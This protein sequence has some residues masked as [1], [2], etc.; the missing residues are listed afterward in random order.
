MLDDLRYRIRALVRRADVEA[1]LRDELDAHVAHEARRF[2]DQGL[3]SGEAWRRA[4]VS[5]GG[6]EPVKEA[7]RDAR[8]VS[9]VETALQDLRYAARALLSRPGFTIVAVG[10]LALGL[11]LNAAIFTAVRSVLLRPLPY[12]EPERLVRIWPGRT[13]SN[14][15]LLA[16]QS[17]LKSFQD[18]AAFSPGW[19]VYV[20]GP[21]EPSH[22]EAARV[23]TNF[24]TTLGVTPAMGRVFQSN[25]SSAGAWNV[26]ILSDAV[27]RTLYGADRGVVGRTV[28]IDGTPHVIVGVMPRDLAFHSPVQLWLPLQ[29]DP[30]SPFFSGQSA[31]A[32]GRLRDGVRADRAAGELA[33]IA[34]RIREQY[35]FAPDYGRGSRVIDLRESI[36]GSARAP[37]LA[38]FGAAGLIVLIAGANVGTLLLLRGANRQR[39][40]VVRRALGASRGRIVL[41][42][43]AESLLLSFAGATIGLGLGAAAMR[44]VPAILPDAFPRRGE[45]GM[46]AGVAITIFAIASVV[47]LVF[48]LAPAMLAGRA[49]A[50]IALRS[51]RAGD[52]GTR[53]GA[54]IRSVLIVGEVALALMLSVGAGLMLRTVWS[55][56]AVDM[57]FHADHVL[58]LRLEPERSRV[59][60]PQQR[61]AYYGEVLSRIR[62]V[63]GVVSVGG[64]HHLP[65]S[66]FSWSGF[67]DIERR[68]Q[69]SNATRPRVVWRVIVGDYFRT[70]GIALLRGRAFDARDTRESPAV[71]IISASMARHL[72]PGQ[73]PLGERIRVENG[74]RNDWATVIGIVG[75]VHSNALDV[76]AGDE[77]YRPILQQSQIFTHLVIRTTS[78]PRSAVPAVQA[79]IRQV[80]GAAAISEIASL[81]QIVDRSIA[82]RR[83]VMQLLVV[84]AAVG[85]A[86]GMIGIHGIVAFAVTQ[87]T[88]EL[89]IRAALGSQ[90]GAIVAMLVGHG[91]RLACC[92]IVLGIVGSIIA[93]RWLTTLLFGVS[94]SD[95]LTYGAFGVVTLLVMLVASYV[96]ARRALRIDPAMALRME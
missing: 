4:R 3:S 40:M 20:S 10:T 79:A 65:L 89:G 36:A 12:H 86:L 85:I 56:Y 84:F 14:A 38:L 76:P 28:K 31:L 6:I 68:P 35:G 8:G 19:G 42:L 69:P 22:L 52:G 50:Q 49:E 94:S 78:D 41:L 13:I 9:F 18:V 17:Q 29:I 74:T 51:G 32:V 46:D 61:P 26:A 59:R 63:P 73:D 44:L 77:M 43:L 30:T 15:E 83:A 58:T 53:S 95:P 34:P 47:G 57:G 25:E 80:D 91:V 7:C 87:R 92:G 27:W 11:G 1:E 93:N 5:L 70:M 54:R 75:D 55:L 96:P 66:G 62:E 82:E 71:V 90:R 23:S 21:T 88:R 37:L 16:F 81:E 33:A 2:R 48:G 60:D 39:E 24:F 67:V 72:W 45:I 64:A